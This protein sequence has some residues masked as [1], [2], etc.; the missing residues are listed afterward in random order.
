MKAIKLLTV[1]FLLVFASAQFSALATVAV[2]NNHK[3]SIE[4][5]VPPTDYSNADNDDDKKKAKK[6]S[7]TKCEPSKEC[8]KTCGPKD[9]KCCKSSTTSTT[10]KTSSTCCK[11]GTGQNK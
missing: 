11:S 9:V 3:T 10:S 6:S 1:A 7:T 8:S 5:L 2:D 4:K